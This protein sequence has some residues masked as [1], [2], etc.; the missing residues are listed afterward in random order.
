M[1]QPE[2]LLDEL[3]TYYATGWNDLQYGT[4]DFPIDKLKWKTC[5]EWIL[6][7]KELA[8]TVW[9]E[10]CFDFNVNIRGLARLA[11]CIDCADKFLKDGKVD[12][13]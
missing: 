8:L 10:Q 3:K 2:T 1:N 13:L 11:G 9:K 4:I 7:M 12:P 6:D 5:D